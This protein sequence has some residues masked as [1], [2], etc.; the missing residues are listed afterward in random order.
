MAQI[1]SGDRRAFDVLFT[2][3]WPSVHRF[4]MT[5]LLKEADAD[6]AAQLVMEKLFV[7]AHRY[8]P[9]YPVM[10]WALAIARWECKT[11]L[12]RRARSRTGPLFDTQSY[13]D[14]SDLAER[15]ELQEALMWAISELSTADQ[16]VILESFWA[17]DLTPTRDAAFR[18]RKQ[19]AVE[20]LRKAWRLLYGD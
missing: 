13:S 11:I 5:L 6:D 15:S 20:R 12:R 18:K 14:Q 2:A 8:N 10:A 1:I 17:D 9:E 16:E 7:Q 4:C 19:R 3:L